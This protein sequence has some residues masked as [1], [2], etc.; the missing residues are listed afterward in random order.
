MK[1][2]IGVFLLEIN[3]DFVTLVVGSD[4]FFALF[5]NVT[6]AAFMFAAFSVTF[7]SIFV[8]FFKYVLSYNFSVLFDI[9]NIEFSVSDI[10]FLPPPVLKT[11][12]RKCHGIQNVP[13]TE[14]ACQASSTESR[15]NSGGQL[16][17]DLPYVFGAGLASEA[18]CT[19]GRDHSGCQRSDGIPYVSW[20]G[21]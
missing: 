14:P 1:L 5:E 18:R 16:S 8:L 2:P 15:H 21:H 4:F 17:Y 6:M 9:G 20:P 11:Q 13:G 3:C 7:F 12:V 10:T 19:K